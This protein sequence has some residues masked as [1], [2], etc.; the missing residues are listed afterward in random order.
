MNPAKMSDAG[1]RFFL[2]KPYRA[3]TLLKTLREAIESEPAGPAV[4]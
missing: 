2:H 3:E 4:N 1:V